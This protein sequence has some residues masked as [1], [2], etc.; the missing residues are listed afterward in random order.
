MKMALRR[1]ARW[2]RLLLFPPVCRY[3]GVRQSIF[4]RTL[5]QLLCPECLRAW[6]EQ[7]K[8]LCPRCASP[9][10][11]CLCMPTALGKSG[12][13]ALVKLS[14]YRAGRPSPLASLVLRAK[15]TPDKEIFRF[16]ALE[17]TMPT[18]TACRELGVDVE[19]MILTYAPRTWKNRAVVGHDQARLLAKALAERLGCSFKALFGR[20]RRGGAQKALS[21]SDRA[22][23]ARA[24]ITLRRGADIK[25][26]TVVVLDD[27]CTTGATLA[28]CTDELYAAGAENVLAVCVAQ[29]DAGRGKKNKF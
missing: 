27:I 11:R 29:T 16:L 10:F 19:G 8:R 7:T 9:Y 14:A 21:S 3:C 24:S 23:N 17:L 20:K 25:D 4:V 2:L 6:A 28:A 15:D 1:V 12:A 22:K 18:F 13:R 5:P 26:K